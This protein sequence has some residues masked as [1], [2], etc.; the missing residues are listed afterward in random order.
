MRR[1]FRIRKSQDFKKTIEGNNSTVTP[2]YRI[3]VRPNE[4]GHLRVGISTSKRLG[5]AVTRVKVRRQVRAFFV[6]YNIY[7]KKY[8]IVI[9]VKP[10]FLTRSS[11]KNREELLEKINKLIAR[12]EN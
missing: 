9:A 3:S 10:D 7:E 6:V 2:A 11:S 4:I 12:G 1:E 5:N 8:D